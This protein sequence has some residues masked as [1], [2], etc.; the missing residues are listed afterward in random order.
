MYIAAVIHSTHVKHKKKHQE[1]YVQYL[2]IHA[3]DPVWP[4]QINGLTYEV[5]ASTVEHP[6]TQV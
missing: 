6:E 1:I 5:C 4:Q 3:V 2:V